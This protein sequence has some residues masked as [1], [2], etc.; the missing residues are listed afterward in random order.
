VTCLT[1]AGGAPARKNKAIGSLE[2]RHQFLL[3]ETSFIRSIGLSPQFAYDA[4]NDDFGIDF[5]IY[6]VPSDKGPLTGGIRFGYS[7]DGNDF[8]A[9]VFVASAFSIF[10]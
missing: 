1:G 5:P 7:S 6:F 9:G 10:Q 4:E 3:S 2:Y 8:A